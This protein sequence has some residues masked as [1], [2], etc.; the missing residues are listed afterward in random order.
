MSVAPLRAFVAF[1]NQNSILRARSASKSKN[2]D[3]VESRKVKEASL[4]IAL[5]AQ[6][7][8]CAYSAFGRTTFD[9]A[10]SQPTLERWLSQT[11]RLAPR[12]C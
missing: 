11:S 4:P 6:S 7:E 12:V 5:C 10:G 1:D 2:A 3:G 9:P 8:N